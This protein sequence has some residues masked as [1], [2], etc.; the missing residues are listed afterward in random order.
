MNDF[1]QG[2]QPTM[3]DSTY[4]G[5]RRLRFQAIRLLIFLSLVLPATPAMGQH[6]TEPIEL[7]TPEGRTVILK[8]DGTWE[9]KKEPEPT[10]KAVAPTTN[11]TPAALSPNFSGDDV[12][13]LL[14]Q[15]VDLR[16]RLVKSEFETSAS[17]EA[18]VAEEKKK[19]ILG[20]R[21]VQ[22]NFYL[23]ASG[24]KAE[25]NADT[26][27]MIFSLPI[28]TNIMVELTRGRNTIDKNT[29]TDLS[30]VTLYRV[31]L[32]SYDDAHVFFDST[33]GLP[34]SGS[35]Y[36]Q[37]FSAKLTLGVEDAK[38][39]KEG[40][41]AVLIVQFEEPYANE[42]HYGND[43]FQTRLIDVQFFDQQTGRVL[44]KL[45]S[46]ALPTSASTSPPKKNTHLEKAQALYNARRDDEALI[47]LR[48]VLVDEPT[49][50][51][52]YLL[53][54]RINLQRDDQE[55]AISAL[56]TSLFWDSKVIDTHILLARIFFARGD[57]PQA[58]QY[59]AAALALD[60][61]NPE[62][63]ALRR[64]IPR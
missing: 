32:G 58:N 54:G 64:Q 10:S 52:A 42:G 43:Q 38:R 63:L 26:Q 15:L 41:K 48:Q 13:T 39:L 40:T 22:D 35:S 16:K 6:P 11:S 44:A 23:V 34:L 29:S 37:R 61:T 51:E 53:A 8:L 24:V 30:R 4:D 31:A 55:A 47:E 36:E 19:P 46:A 59:V 1:N 56:K 7:R 5:K 45:G 9:Y 62:A 14:H 17:Y 28:E 33:N 60:P 25:Y 3:K 50:A 2:R 57:R 12:T 18:R 27:M 20:S 21:T 49:N